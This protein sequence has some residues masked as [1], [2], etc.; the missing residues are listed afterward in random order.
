MSLLDYY[1]QQPSGG[2][3]R[4]GVPHPTDYLGYG[5]LAPSAG[6]DEPPDP[7]ALYSY[8]APPEPPAPPPPLP[9]LRA[10]GAADVSAPKGTA[11]GQMSD[12]GLRGMIAMNDTPTAVKVS[13]AIM[14]VNPL[15]GLAFKGLVDVAQE[16]NRD[17]AIAAMQSRHPTEG[18]MATEAA[19]QAMGLGGNAPAVGGIGI[20]PGSAEAASAAIGHGVGSMG[21]AATGAGGTGG[22]APGSAAAAGAAVGHGFGGMGAAA[23]G[24]GTP[25]GGGGGGGGGSVICTALYDQALM[26]E[27]VYR[28]DSEFGRSVNPVV[29]A[30]YWVWAKPIAK[31]MRKSR[32]VTKVVHFMARPWIKAMAERAGIGG[33]SAVGEAYLKVGIP[34]C[35]VIGVCAMWLKFAADPSIVSPKAG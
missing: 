13:Q 4:N 22:P 8:M 14:P 2:L 19:A 35:Y 21:A 9:E 6:A 30:G 24:A 28:A 18:T 5:L 31:A 15:L 33:G 12:A 16:S 34:A 11:I 1:G 10:P 25:G 20:A 17:A 26:D 7:T 23:T 29:L 27:A 3:L 32:K